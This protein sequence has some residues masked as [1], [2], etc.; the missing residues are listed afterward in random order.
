MLSSGMD[1]GPAAAGDLP[2]IRD[3]LRGCAL[4][5]DD[6]D[7]E[8]AQHFL[9]AR[10]GGELA[11]CIGLE[12]HAEA[13]LLRSFAVA[14]SHRRRGVGA[15]LHER[16][17]E[18]ARNLGT[19]DLFILTTTV[20]ERALRNGFEDVARESVPEVIRE[21]SQFRALCPASAACMRLRLT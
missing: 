13:G 12:V 3:L 18:L 11:G 5:A 19:R 9:V 16:A 1:I 17:V 20:R 2:A 21:G 8:G 4:T 15:V 10:E 7:G 14:Q 6:V